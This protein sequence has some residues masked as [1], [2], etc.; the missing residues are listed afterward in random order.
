[1]N[2]L[3]KMRGLADELQVDVFTTEFDIIAFLF[4]NGKSGIEDIRRS[5]R[6]SPGAV[7]YKIRS[8]VEAGVVIRRTSEVDARA[9]F[10]EL[11][12][13]AFEMLNPIAFPAAEEL[14][15]VRAA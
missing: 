6:G 1:M 13:E 8:M 10:Y 3:S 5:V 11:S 7:S 14:R 9:S 4:C 15:A 12:P 2:L